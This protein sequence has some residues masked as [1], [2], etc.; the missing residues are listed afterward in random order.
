MAF[1][2]IKPK[3]QAVTLAYE[4]QKVVSSE[5][6]IVGGIITKLG[7]NEFYGVVGKDRVIDVDELK[8]LYEQAVWP[9]AKM[10]FKPIRSH[11]FTYF[12]E[13]EVKHKLPHS[14]TGGTRFRHVDGDIGWGI[15]RAKLW[16][17]IKS[18]FGYEDR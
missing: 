3:E 7:T 1:P 15:F 4:Q 2:K 11:Y 5:R 12:R 17:N 6:D 13:Y 16:K 14:G 8:L 18:V 10:Y 9:V